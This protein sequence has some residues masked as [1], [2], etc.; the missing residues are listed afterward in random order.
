M[1]YFKKLGKTARRNYLTYGLVILAFVILQVMMGSL[2]SSL[3]GMLVP[4]CAYVVMAVSLNLTVGI[5][6]ELSLGHAGF[7]SVGAFMGVV[8]A[9]SLQEIIPFAPV[10]LAISMVVGAAFAAVDRNCK[11]PG[12][13]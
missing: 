10:R 11:K 4:I 1:A 12:F 5:L 9:A 2:S 8:A 3:K 6:G 7:M 13:N